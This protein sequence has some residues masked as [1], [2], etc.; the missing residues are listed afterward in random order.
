MT[1][2]EMSVVGAPSDPPPAIGAARIVA[3]LV[4][5]GVLATSTRF[6]VG[7][8]LDV[9][10]FDGD[11]AELA[12]RAPHLR[13]QAGPILELRTPTRSFRETAD[14]DARYW[15]WALVPSGSPP[16]EQLAQLR[17]SMTAVCE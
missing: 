3:L 1:Q 16:A 11:A 7:S 17:A 2:S 9:S 8:G 12:R 6:L 13:D 4:L 5:V 10:T 15:L 14:E